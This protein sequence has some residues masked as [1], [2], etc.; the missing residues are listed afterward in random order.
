LRQA[1]ARSFEQ[2]NERSRRCAIVGTRAVAA[3]TEQ[4][5]RCKSQKD[6]TEPRRRLKAHAMN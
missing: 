6:R 2:G 3:H 1:E 5:H 4:Q